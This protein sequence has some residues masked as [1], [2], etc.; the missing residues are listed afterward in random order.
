MKN[1]C[2]IEECND[3][4]HG[5]RLCG[6]H[7]RREYLYGSPHDIIVKQ[8]IRE[9]CSMPNCDKKYAAKGLCLQHYNALPYHKERRRRNALKY[10]KNNRD[11]AIEATSRYLEKMSKC[12]NISGNMY[13][14]LIDCWSRIIKYRD[15]KCVICGSVNTLNAHHIF[16]KKDYPMLSLNENNGITLCRKCHRELHGGHWNE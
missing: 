1:I 13:K 5:N 6:K 11:K 7:Y 4:V 8:H 15:K 10:M 16:Y 3:F 14:I 9:I 2:I 12:F